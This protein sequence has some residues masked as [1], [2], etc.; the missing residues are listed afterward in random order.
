M[1]LVILI[2]GFIFGKLESIKSTGAVLQEQEPIK[3]Q[4]EGDYKKQW[5]FINPLL[6]CGEMN[7]ISNKTINKMKE[8]INDFISEQKT[9]GVSKV[10]V[11]FRDLNN[12]PWL[13]INEKEEFNPG[14]LLKVPMMMRILKDTEKDPLILQQKIMIKDQANLLVQYYKPEVS[15]ETDKA[16][17]VSELVSN[18]IIY[19]NNDATRAIEQF[20]G[21][22][23]LYKS[24][25]ELGVKAPTDG[26]YRISTRVYGSFFRVLYNASYLNDELSE[27]ALKLLAATSF[28]NGI[29]AGEPSSTIIAH[30]FGERRV[31]SITKQLHDCGIIY[32]P[33]QPYL[34]CVMTR[35]EE[36]DQ[37]AAVIAQISK[38]VYEGVSKTE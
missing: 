19:S 38:I 4:R 25:E 9:E 36:F 7:N 3:N 35:G 5:R 29:K 28:S 2:I 33:N 37:L 10:S 15:L 8:K 34:L 13:G 30:K 1:T 17:T 11:Y 16:Y 23:R 26:N 12:G 20:I 32:Y 14:S 27:Q 31:N 18:M 22:D 24:Y 6:D 21:E